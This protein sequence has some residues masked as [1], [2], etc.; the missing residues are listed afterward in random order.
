MVIQ[1]FWLDLMPA[2]LLLISVAIF[3]I[4]EW[5]I[6]RSVSA[7]SRRLNDEG[8][9]GETPKFYV[10]KGGRDDDW[11]KFIFRDEEAS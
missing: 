9:L 3:S 2:Y 6:G 11:H 8:G 10:I 7:E 1:S 4:G 5:I